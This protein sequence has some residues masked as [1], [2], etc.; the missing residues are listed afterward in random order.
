MTKA[1]EV[2]KL[3]VD[4]FVWLTHLVNYSKFPDSLSV[5]CIFDTKAKLEQSRQAAKDQLIID[6]IMTELKQINIGFNNIN[7]HISFDT[8]EACESEHKGNWQNRFT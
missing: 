2:A 7:Q 3:E 6:L 4:G 5:I 8:E 1:C